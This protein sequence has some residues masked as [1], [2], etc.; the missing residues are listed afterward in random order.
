MIIILQL[1]IVFCYRNSKSVV[2][3]A[4]KSFTGFTYVL[5]FIYDLFTGQWLCV[6]KSFGNLTLVNRFG[7]LFDIFLLVIK[8]FVLF[9]HQY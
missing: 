8:I 6:D 1:Q 5:E 7:R 4:G 3:D 2:F 9:D